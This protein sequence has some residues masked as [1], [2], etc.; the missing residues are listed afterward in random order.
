MNVSRLFTR[1]MPGIFLQIDVFVSVN[2]FLHQTQ[3]VMALDQIMMIY[4]I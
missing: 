2:N 4:Y 1:S 3:L